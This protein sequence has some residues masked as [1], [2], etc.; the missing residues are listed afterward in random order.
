MKLDINE[1][2]RKSG[3]G[4]S[5]LAT[6]VDGN[7]RV[8]VH[9]SDRVRWL[10]VGDNSL[11][12]LMSLAF[13]ERI[14][15]AYQ[16]AMLGAL[17]VRPLPGRV[18][19]LGLGGGAFARF[20]Q[21]WF[22]DA[23]M[24]S[25]E[26]SPVMVDLARR[27]FGLPESSEVEVCSAES[28]IEKDKRNWDLVLCD[29]FEGECQ[30]PLLEQRSF[31]RGLACRLAPGGVLAINLMPKTNAQLFSVLLTLRS[32]LPHI[33]LIEVPGCGNIVLLASREGFSPAEDSPLKGLPAE[34]EAEL[35]AQLDRLQ[36]IPLPGV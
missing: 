9:Q 21:R 27:Y 4:E 32:F 3:E 12:S 23:R 24:L 10:Y 2:V 5:L 19:D 31:Y 13:P 22:P 29:L 8:E 20:F 26:R 25:V 7:G 16:V 14:E 17:A 18:L 35:C 1:L 33:A 28:F 15:L 34:V 11:L 6:V 36:F 30:S